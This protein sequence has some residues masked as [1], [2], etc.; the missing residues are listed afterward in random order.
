MSESDEFGH[1]KIF[2]PDHVFEAKS[3]KFGM[4]TR[5]GRLFDISSVLG[6]K[7]KFRVSEKVKILVMFGGGC[8]VSEAGDI[9]CCKWQPILVIHILQVSIIWYL[10]S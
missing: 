5:F 9:C 3:M 7:V 4:E 2:I 10:I 1:F 8:L 6:P